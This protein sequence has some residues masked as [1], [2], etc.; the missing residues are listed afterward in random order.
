MHRQCTNCILMVERVAMMSVRMI[1]DSYN[2]RLNVE[3]R[4]RLRI[5]LTLLDI[6]RQANMGR[7]GPRAKAS[8]AQF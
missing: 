3:Q 7:R 2:R 1:T 6:R 4:E 5:M 8:R